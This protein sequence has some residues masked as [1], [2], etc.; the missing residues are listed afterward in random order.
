MK[1][2]KTKAAGL[3]LIDPKL[4][5]EPK[6]DLSS[7]PLTLTCGQDQWTRVFRND[8]NEA[9][10]VWGRFTIQIDHRGYWP[11]LKGNPLVPHDDPCDKFG[12]AVGI[13]RMIAA[14]SR[15]EL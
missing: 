4:I 15:R 14:Q 7:L 1:L 9:I 8:Q 13:I 11:C 12:L 5:E 2:P 6:E 10:Y 3:I